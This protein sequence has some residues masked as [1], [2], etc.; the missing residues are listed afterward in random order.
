MCGGKSKL[1]KR[2]ESV[3]AVTLEVS[4]TKRRIRDHYF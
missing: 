2:L 3:Q 1:S 4:D